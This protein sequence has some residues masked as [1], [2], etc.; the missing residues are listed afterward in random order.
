MSVEM[1]VSQEVYLD[2]L[3]KTFGSGNAGYIDE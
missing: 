2:K 3:L 1:I